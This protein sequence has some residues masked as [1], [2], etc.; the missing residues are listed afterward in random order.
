MCHRGYAC[1]ASDSHPI[2]CDPGTFSV[3]L[4]L[5][6][7]LCTTGH[8]CADPSGI[9]YIAKAVANIYHICIT[10]IFNTI[11]GEYTDY[12]SCIIGQLPF[13]LLQ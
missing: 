2:P 1:P 12:S 6:C 13:S 4:A 10:M 5:T 3:D 7:S 9:I 8:Y 11:H